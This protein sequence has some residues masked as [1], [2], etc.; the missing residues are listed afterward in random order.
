[1]DILRKRLSI[2]YGED[3]PLDRTAL[4][5]WCI[6]RFEA[7]GASAAM[8]AFREEEKE[9]HITLI[10]GG[11]VIVIDINLAVDRSDP[12]NPRISVTG[13]KTTYAVPNGSA[14]SVTAGSTSLDGFLANTLGE[15]LAEVQKED[16]LQDPEGAHKTGSRIA[17]GLKY[18]MM[19]D[20]LAEDEGDQ[21]LRWFN[22]VDLLALEVERFAS[23]EAA[24]IAKYVTLL[25]SADYPT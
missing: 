20:K 10:L 16:E 8:E 25:C 2:I 21:G 17:D 5:D 22:N 14:G 3:I 24:A 12:L 7:W 19:L 4:I 15:F 13:V 1:M 6:S 9:G 11:K 18:L 23:E